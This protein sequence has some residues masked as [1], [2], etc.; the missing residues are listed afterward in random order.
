LQLAT[1]VQQRVGG[2]LHEGLGQQLSGIAM[3]LQGL[4]ARSIDVAPELWSELDKIVT[5]INGAVS[6]TRLLARGL[7]P[8]RAS[9]KSLTEGFEELVN[10][11]LAVYGQRVR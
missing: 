4:K 6:R 2:D 7:S 9:T 5:L 8:V 1:Q 3:M 11:V 10:N